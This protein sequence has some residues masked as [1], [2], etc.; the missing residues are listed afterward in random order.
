MKKQLLITTILAILIIW[1]GTALAT[2]RLHIGKVPIRMIPVA[3]ANQ[4]QTQ[5]GHDDSLLIIKGKIDM[6]TTD[7]YSVLPSFAGD[8]LIIDGNPVPLMAPGFF[9]KANYV[10]QF[11]SSA[12]A[13][14]AIYFYVSTGSNPEYWEV[15]QKINNLTFKSLGKARVKYQKNGNFKT[16][17]VTPGNNIEITKPIG[18][19]QPK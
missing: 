6:G 13:G 4:Y 16:I 12:S 18:P 10:P 1:A 5:S 11:K 14:W 7:Y 17:S 3:P 2:D 9:Y 19:V 8:W 15:F